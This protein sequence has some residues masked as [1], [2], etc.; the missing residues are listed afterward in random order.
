MKYQTR[1]QALILLADGTI[2]HGKAVGGKEGSAFG[3][4]CFNTGMTGYQEI[5]TD[6]SYFGQ[7]MVTTNAH[8]GNYGVAD[9]EV[10]SDSIKIAGLICRNF[11]YHHSRYSADDSLES[12]FDKNNLLAIS[13]VDTRALVSYIRDNGAMNAVITT[14]VDNIEALKKQLAEV[15]DMNGLELASKVSTQEPY[16][17]GNENATYKISAL[18]IGIKKNILRNLA[19]R[20]CYIKVFPY[21][22]TYE[23]MAT[24]NPDGYF[25]SNGPGDPEPLTQ[26]IATAKDIL[27]TGAPLFGICLG[28]QVLALANGISTYK[29]HNGHRGINHPI[30]NLLT[31]KGEITSQNHGFAINREETEAHPEVEITHVHLN[32]NTVA[33][34]RLKGK[35]VFSVQYH[36]EAG[37][38]PN[39]AKYLFDQFL[40]NIKN[41]KLEKAH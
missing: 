38:G 7:L 1:K 9:D 36:P 21:D 23:E 5:F 29:M 40:E 20:D 39:D 6:P 19:E 41:T 26:A 12:F 13:D 8:I 34:I 30:K 11:S 31:G 25:L 28:H 33:G 2:F 16:F 3:E 35:P 18:D 15:P 37:P 22:T 32:D 17:Y 4:V 24:F 14:E 27:Q 10:E